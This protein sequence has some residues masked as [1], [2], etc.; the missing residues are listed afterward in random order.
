MN[1]KTWTISRA[2]FD[3]TGGVG[4]SRLM[5]DFP[6][7]WGA[8]VLYDTVT[9]IMRPTGRHPVTGDPLY[10]TGYDRYEQEVVTPGVMGMSDRITP[11]EGTVPAVCIT[12]STVYDFDVATA[13]HQHAQHLVL[14]FET[15]DG[16]EPPIEGWGKDDGFTASQWTV[17]R[18]ALVTMGADP[19]VIDG[20]RTNN[21][22]GTRKEFYFAL[23]RYID[24]QEE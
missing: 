23:E 4:K 16:S 5:E 2:F 7:V 13:I 19:E 21:P 18:N 14:A 8:T 15:V 11:L 24:R 20:W 10:V 17:Y 22:E 6:M 12:A 1:L 9:N 3:G